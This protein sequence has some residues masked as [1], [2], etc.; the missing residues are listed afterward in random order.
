LNGGRGT[1]WPDGKGG[2]RER[3]STG[4]GKKRQLEGGGWANNQNA[5]SAKFNR[6]H[7]RGVKK[8]KTQRGGGQQRGGN[9]TPNMS[10]SS[11]VGGG[12]KGRK[13]VSGGWG[14]AV[15]K[16]K[17]WNGFRKHGSNNSG[18]KVA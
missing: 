6:L 8:A 17:N 9:P 12:K 2:R 3:K 11:S 14:K 15:G 7:L 10:Q 16:K 5:A 4:K 1:N 18:L 13:D